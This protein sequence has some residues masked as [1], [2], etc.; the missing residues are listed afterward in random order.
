[1]ADIGTEYGV[2]PRAKRVAFGVESGAGHGVVGFAS[3]IEIRYEP[4]ADVLLIFDRAGGKFVQR[5]RILHTGAE[6]RRLASDGR[7]AEQLAAV[8]AVQLAQLLAVDGARIVPHH[9]AEIALAPMSDQVAQQRARPSDA[10]LE[11]E[12]FHFGKAP[13]YPAHEQRLGGR[14]ACRRE[15]P[16][17]VVHETRD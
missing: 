4:P 6:L 17:M 9:L 12:E 11:K 8:A 14:F 10:A 2:K 13:R 7:L 15:M 3:K 5:R 16:D 1:M